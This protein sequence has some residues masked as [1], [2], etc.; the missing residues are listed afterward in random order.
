MIRNATVQTEKESYPCTAIVYKI[1]KNGQTSEAYVGSTIQT[2]EQI[3]MGHQRA[4]NKDSTNTCGSQKMC[5]EVLVEIEECPD[6]NLHVELARALA[7]SEKAT[8]LCS[9]HHLIKS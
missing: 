1:F 4:E 5:V 2:V 3:M 7:L 9:T 6:K 8:L